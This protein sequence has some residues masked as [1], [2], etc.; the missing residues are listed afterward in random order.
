MILEGSDVPFVVQIPGFNGY[1]TVR[2][3]TF[4]NEWRERIVFNYKVNDIAKVYVE[5][6]NNRD[7]SFIAISSGNNKF[8]LANIDGTKVNEPFDTIML[9]EYISKCKFIGFES[10]IS[11]EF[12]AHKLDSLLKEPILSKFTIENKTGEKQTLKTY[13]RQNING[14]CDDNGKL[15]DF[16]ID[17]LYGI[18]NTDKDVVLLQFYIID[19]ISFKKSDFLIKY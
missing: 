8:E 5:Y 13:Y 2:Y 3:N 15:Y 6:P 4:L 12:M 14:S 9:K 11:N 10:Y 19:P 1:L 7:E 17:N 18:I 16:D